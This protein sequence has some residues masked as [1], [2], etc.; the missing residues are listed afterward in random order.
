YDL[1][2]IRSLTSS[3]RGVRLDALLSSFVFLV[4]F[5]ALPSVTSGQD[6]NL[7]VAPPP[8]KLLSKDE[9][10]LLDAKAVDL[11]AR[12]KLALELMDARLD[13]AEKWAG[14]RQFDTMFNELGGFHALM[15]DSLEF[16]NR[17][18][19][20]SNGKVLDNFKRLEIG[21]RA[22]SPRIEVIRR[23][24]PIRYD[25][26]VRRLMKFVRDARTKATE[27]LFSDTVVPNRK[28]GEN[29]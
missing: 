5:F 4:I 14:S 22:F 17:R 6:D 9:R 7:E 20:G 16:L 29:L 26:Y 25:D 24:L 27:P 2:A 15:D 11:K 28:N 12:T 10:S 3:T 19:S 21:L 23:E 13:A 8:V 1:L 18:D